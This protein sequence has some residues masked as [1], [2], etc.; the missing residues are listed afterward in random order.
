MPPENIAW[1][2]G[3]YK[4]LPRTRWPR[5]AKSSIPTFSVRP[6][7]EPAPQN[8]VF[9]LNLQQEW[10]VSAERL[11]QQLAEKQHIVGGR[12]AALWDPSHPIC[13]SCCVPHEPKFDL[14]ERIFS[15]WCCR[16]S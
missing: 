6:E 13:R 5:N 9:L 8:P 4:I 7:L 2:L 11:G 12:F 16:S 1:G 14:A 15:D 3:S 10:W